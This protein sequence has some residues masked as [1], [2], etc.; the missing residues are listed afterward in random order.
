MQ[1]RQI[2]SEV[3]QSAIIR[4][5]A[6]LP[7]DAPLD[8]DLEFLNM[9][10]LAFTSLTPEQLL[11]QIKQIEKDIGREDRGFWGPREIDIDILTYATENIISENLVIPHKY[12]LERDFVLDPLCELIPDWEYPREGTFYKMQLREIKQLKRK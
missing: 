2:I 8:W 12:M 1:Q 5:K 11:T 3:T 10:I 7:K 9:A 4:S 6:L